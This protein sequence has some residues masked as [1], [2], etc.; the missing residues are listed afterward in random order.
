MCRQRGGQ[1][2]KLQGLRALRQSSLYPESSMELLKDLKQ[3]SNMIRYA[4]FKKSLN[5]KEEYVGM[6]SKRRTKGNNTRKNLKALKIGKEDRF[7][8]IKRWK[9]QDL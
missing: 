8:G 6:L 4:L 7:N 3:R 1:G 2:S 9:M 5:Q